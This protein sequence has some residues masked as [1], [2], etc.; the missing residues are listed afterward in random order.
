MN[1][2]KHRYKLY[3]KWGYSVIGSLW[4]LFWR[5][6][7]NQSNWLEWKPVI[8]VGRNCLKVVSLFNSYQTI[9]TKLSCVI[10]VWS[11]WEKIKVGGSVFMGRDRGYPKC[12][13]DIAFEHSFYWSVSGLIISFALA[14]IILPKPNFLIP[15]IFYVLVLLSL[16]CRYI[17]FDIKQPL[18]KKKKGNEKEVS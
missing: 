16:F 4:L 8:V 12:K 10:A 6:E 9:A 7:W 13:T 15:I 18:E 11:Y 17:Y 14:I 5:Y 2:I 1:K 3:R